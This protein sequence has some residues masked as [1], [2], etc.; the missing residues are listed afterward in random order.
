MVGVVLP[1]QLCSGAI[2][3][4]IVDGL[5]VF[6]DFLKNFS[7]NIFKRRSQYPNVLKSEFLMTQNTPRDGSQGVVRDVIDGR[8]R[9][10]TN[11]VGF[12]RF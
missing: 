7:N 11:G 10:E 6:G 9:R 5:T 4:E 12:K 1:G 3:V 2:I 8:G